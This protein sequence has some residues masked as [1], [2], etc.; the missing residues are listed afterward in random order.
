MIP[1][2]ILSSVGWRAIAFGAAVFAI[3][4]AGLYIRHTG[5]AA[6]EEAHR[7]KLAEHLQ[8]G[9]E[10]A[11]VIARQDAEV[12]EYYERVKTRIETQIITVRDEVAHEVPADCRTCALNPLGLQRLNAALRGLRTPAADPEQPDGPVPGATAPPRWQLPGGVRPLGDDRP[13]LLKLRGETQ[14][15]GEGFSQP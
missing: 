3:A 13:A 8:R 10:Q 7:A 5:Y 12:S 1:L 14:F 15:A 2:P 11:Q 4:G 9:I 6:C